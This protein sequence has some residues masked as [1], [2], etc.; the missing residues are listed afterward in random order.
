M[1]D[2]RKNWKYFNRNIGNVVFKEAGNFVVPF[3]KW[4]SVC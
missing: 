4:N 2:Q 3:A 1:I